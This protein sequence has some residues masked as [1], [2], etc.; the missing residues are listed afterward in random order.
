MSCL[1]RRIDKLTASDTFCNSGAFSG[2]F[3]IYS[4]FQ[5]FQC[6]ICDSLANT[7][8]FSI[9]DWINLIRQH[10][11][12]K[13]PEASNQNQ[14]QCMVDVYILS[15]DAQILKD[16]ARAICSLF[17]VNYVENFPDIA[18]RVSKFD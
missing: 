7:Q 15:S 12:L 11:F 10:A 8:T 1:I 9:F 2:A 18:L 14:R 16:G 6:I 17:K 3:Y 5:G 13:Q 4:A